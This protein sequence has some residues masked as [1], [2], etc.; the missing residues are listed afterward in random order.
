MDPT[1]EL[2]AA[3][4]RRFRAVEGSAADTAA[5]ARRRAKANEVKEKPGAQL[6]RSPLRTNTSQASGE[7][8]DSGSDAGS[9][10]LPRRV[11]RVRKPAWVVD[12]GAVDPRKF[13]P[14]MP[15]IRE[16][17]WIRQDSEGAGYDE[18]TLRERLCKALCDR[19]SALQ[20]VAE[21]RIA[22]ADRS[23]DLDVEVARLRSNAKSVRR[24]I[25]VAREEMGQCRV[26]AVNAQGAG[27]ADACAVGGRGLSLSL[28]ETEALSTEVSRLA[29][30]RV[31]LEARI[32]SVETELEWQASS[33]SRLE[34]QLVESRRRK[35]SLQVSLDIARACIAAAANEPSTTWRRVKPKNAASHPGP[36]EDTGMPF[37]RTA[38]D[39]PA[40]LCD[41]Y[42]LD[43]VD[44]PEA[45]PDK[46]KATKDLEFVYDLGLGLSGQMSVE[47]ALEFARWAASA[48]ARSQKRQ[49][50]RASSDVTTTE[51]NLQ[52]GGQDTEDPEDSGMYAESV[53][54][55]EQVLERLR[56]RA[57]GGEVPDQGSQP[58]GAAVE[59]A[60]E[61]PRQG[62]LSRSG[63]GGA[64]DAT[65]LQKLLQ[66]LA[67]FDHAEASGDGAT[68]GDA[69]MPGAPPRDPQRVVARLGQTGEDSHHV[70]GIPSRRD[71]VS[72]GVV[73]N[74]DASMFVAPLKDL[75]QVIAQLSQPREQPTPSGSA[76]GPPEEE[77][78][79]KHVATVPKSAGPAFASAERAK[80]MFPRRLSLSSFGGPAEAFIRQKYA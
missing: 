4:S 50:S 67:Q 16:H 6:L 20:E 13:A 14:K 58:S 3:L 47:R 63:T 26:G 15:W 25:E 51:E 34:E 24:E 2:L 76:V 69:S 35:E 60:E 37:G 49:R 57:E 71:E 61:H 17:P 75:Q 22:V 8:S 55:L 68:S 66:E 48:A 43:A 59:A 64:P 12:T 36:A 53:K 28:A 54:T 1:P 18:A 44:C 31:A 42:S 19:D 79:V 5:A 72:D 40:A 80:A 7:Q 74:G 78:A 56:S 39:D 45:D 21:I 77:M 29:T 65:P 27:T 32:N 23:A 73:T 41:S 9:S 33:R 62:L 70:E 30:E 10:R 46:S 11:G 52:A 38:L